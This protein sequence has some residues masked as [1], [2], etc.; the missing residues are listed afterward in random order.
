MAGIIGR[1]YLPNFQ[2]FKDNIKYGRIIHINK[3]YFHLY[4]EKRIKGNTKKAAIEAPGRICR[5][6]YWEN[7]EKLSKDIVRYPGNWKIYSLLA[8]DIRPSMCSNL[9]KYQEKAKRNPINP[10]KINHEI[11]LIFLCFLLFNESIR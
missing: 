3:K 2:E 9:L 6:I 8:I 5:Y 11:N 10:E 4:L 1:R 7:N